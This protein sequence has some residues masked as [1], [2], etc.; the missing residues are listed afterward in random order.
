M[1][2]HTS[3]WRGTVP[4]SGLGQTMNACSKVFAGDIHGDHVVSCAGIIGIKR[5]NV[6]RDT[7]QICYFT[8]EMED[9]MCVDLT[10]Y[11]RL[12]Q[13]EMADFVSERAVIDAAQRK[14]GKYMDKCVDIGYGISPIFLSLPLGIRGRC[15]YLAEAD[16]EV[17]H[18]LRHRD[19]CSYSYL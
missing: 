1:E 6:V 11:S 19:T 12:S 7:L 16:S 2:D 14:C 8:R 3:D 4:I 17:L 9:L 18:D 10:G 5:H 15:S 13:T